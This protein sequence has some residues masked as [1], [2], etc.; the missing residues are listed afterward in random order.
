MEKFINNSILETKAS[1]LPDPYVV[2]TDTLEYD[3]SNRLVDHDSDRR[4][5]T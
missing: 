5:P 3:K 2:P 1:R 4:I